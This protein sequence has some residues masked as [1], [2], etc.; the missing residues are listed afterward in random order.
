MTPIHTKECPCVRRNTVPTTP[1]DL[2]SKTKHQGKGL[3]H[4]HLDEP[5]VNMEIRV[6]TFTDCLPSAR[7][8]KDEPH[9]YLPVDRAPYLCSCCSPRTRPAKC[10]A[11]GGRSLVIPTQSR[12]QELTDV[13]ARKGEAEVHRQL[14]EQGNGAQDHRLKG[15]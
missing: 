9:R 13:E 11:H 7:R 1:R 15:P 8:P 6:T 4:I 12:H 5:R 10:P 14:N 3:N 2:L